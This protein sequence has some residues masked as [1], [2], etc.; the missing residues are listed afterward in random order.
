MMKLR[1]IDMK[2]EDGV[3]HDEDGLIPE[4]NAMVICDMGNNVSKF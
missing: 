1:S 4:G 3:F 2:R